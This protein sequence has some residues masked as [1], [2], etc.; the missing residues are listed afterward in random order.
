MAWRRTSSCTAVG[1]AVGSGR[2][3]PDAC[4]QRVTRSS[5]PTLTGM[6]ERVH[7]CRDQLV[8]LATHVEDVVAVLEFEDLHD[9]VLCAGSYGGMAITGAADRVAGRIRLVVYVDALAPTYGQSGLDLLPPAFGDAVRAGISERG[10]GWRVPMPPEL[11]A[12]L[13]PEGSIAPG[14]RRPSWPG[15][16][17]TR[18]RPS[19]TPSGPQAPSTA[20]RAPSCAAPAAATTRETWAVI[21]SSPRRPGPLG[22]LGVSG[23]ARPSRRPPLRS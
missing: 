1:A 21:P 10:P 4:G 13:L 14:L 11:L 6:G 18:R 15:S 23:T 17:T 9:V 16:P 2:R 5:P 8:D 3:S 19:P 22:G 20:C 12:P 7:L